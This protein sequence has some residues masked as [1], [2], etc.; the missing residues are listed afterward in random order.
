[1]RR[2]LENW[3][4]RHQHPLSRGLH[5][6]AI[7]LL[8]AGAVLALLQFLDGRW[9]LWWRPVGLIAIS[10]AMQWLGHLIEG[11]DMGEV[12]LIKRRL[13]LPFVAIAPR[14]RRK[15]GPTEQE[16]TGNVS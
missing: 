12:V 7:P 11:N 8:P 5:F 4:E 3:L 10:Y 9:S 6:L 14:Y 1:M 2:W 15:N 13:G 16:S